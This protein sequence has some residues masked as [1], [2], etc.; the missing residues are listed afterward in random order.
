MA[1]Y[2]SL[3]FSLLPPSRRWTAAHL[4]SVLDL[5]R[6][7]T[8]Q[9]GA[10]RETKPCTPCRQP[11]TKPVPKRTPIKGG[12]VCPA[13]RHVLAPRPA[14]QAAQ[15][16]LHALQGT[17][18][19][20]AQVTLQF[21]GGHAGGRQG[22]EEPRASAAAAAAAAARAPSRVQERAGR[23][24]QCRRW[25]VPQ[26]RH[27]DFHVLSYPRLG[28]LGLAWPMCTRWPPLSRRRLCSTLPWASVATL[29]A[30][31]LC[32]SAI[33]RHMGCSA[34]STAGRRG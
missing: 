1:V 32:A 15:K 8:R 18:W 2:H 19:Q 20:G 31:C 33:A 11:L 17:T 7:A 27:H 30:A 12:A 13:G 26:A 21:A 25:H 3:S 28:P 34:P 6:L 29:A 16:L 23:P 9:A 5:A 4:A 24:T 10:N 14:K 22:R